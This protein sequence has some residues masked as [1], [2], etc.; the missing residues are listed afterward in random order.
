MTV[1][2]QLTPWALPGLLAVLVVLRDLVYLWPRRRE[3]SVPALL[4][5]SLLSG[6]WAVTHLLAVVSA[7]PAAK[8][9]LARGLYVPALLAPVALLA[10]A[11]L[12]TR[13]SRELKHGPA[14]LLYL[15]TA[16]GMVL[17]LWDDGFRVLV[18]AVEVVDRSGLAGL[19]VQV[20]PAH[21][22]VLAARV[23]AAGTAAWILLSAPVGPGH[24]LRS[25]SL[26]VTATLLVL[27]PAAA[28]LGAGPTALW[29][30]LSPV[31]F[32]LASAALSV[33]LLRPRLLGVGPVARKLVLDELR[34]PILVMD[35]NGT[36]V[37]VN[38]AAEGTLGVRPFGDVPLALGTLWASSRKE[39]RDAPA[40]TLSVLRPDG[41]EEERTFDVAVT[42][43]EEGGAPG[44]TAL[45]LRDVTQR[46]R[47]EQQLREAHQELESANDELK[48][49]ANTDALTG[50]ANRRCFMEALHQ[51]V[52]R[53]ARY[54]RPLSLVLLDLDHF[55]KVNDT[56]GHA[57]GD[58]VLRVAAGVLQAACR[59]VDLAARLGGEELALILPE[60]RSEGAA[61][62]AERIRQEMESRGHRS[63]DGVPFHV[64]ASFGVAST[65]GGDRSAEALLQVADEALYAAKGGGR[66]RVATAP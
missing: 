48:R 28:E 38:R 27:L 3:R 37:D 29:R 64:T 6:V 41:G 46:R 59:D 21:W 56:H 25:R 9:A 50:L 11:L 60:T 1:S 19:T 15:V 22:G 62:V 14:I 12:H 42:H 31:G 39:A 20:G 30:D 49:L 24:A 23:A 66:N 5:V 55:K 26:V 45:R 54:V 44:R 47:M 40:V 17:V 35:G 18:R 33:G 36:I 63:P 10:F 16:A 32:A 51:E 7:D 43:L 57:A 2:L 53:A 58:E 4:T 13:R 61:A 65:K 8:A 52:E 34:D